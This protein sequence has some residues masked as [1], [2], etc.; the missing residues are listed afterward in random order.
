MRK[1]QVARLWNRCFWGGHL[2]LEHDLVVKEGLEQTLR[3]ATCTANDALIAADGVI[4]I[5]STATLLINTAQDVVYIVR[6]KALAV[7]DGREH[8]RDSMQRHRA[9]VRVLIHFEANFNA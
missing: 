1:W 7:K 6:E 4:T 3:G 2:V 5:H 9:T 8:T